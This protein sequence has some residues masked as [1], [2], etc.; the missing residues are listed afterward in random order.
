MK[1]FE[2]SRELPKCS[3]VSQCRWKKMVPIDLLTSRL[4]QKLQFGKNTVSA[5]HSEAKC[6]RISLP[7]Q[8]GFF[9]RN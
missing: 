7:V 2:I 6:N 8:I 1:K 9:Y 5:E 3:K 4:P